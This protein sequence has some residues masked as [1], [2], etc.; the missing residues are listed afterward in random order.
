MLLYKNS[1]N[2]VYVTV[3]EKA[4]TFSGFY[5]FQF[6]NS[7]GTF[8]CISNDSSLYT[9]RYNKFNIIDTGA[10]TPNPLNE[11]VRLATGDYEYTIYENI[12]NTNLNPIGL[13]IVEV[14]DAFVFDA[15]SNKDK[16]YTKGIK[17]N[18]VYTPT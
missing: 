16:T 1:S 4:I 11:Q 3:T 8:Y 7:T 12:N 14:G 9:N 10:S 13:N 5:L 18:K 2:A 17:L 15:T 6:T